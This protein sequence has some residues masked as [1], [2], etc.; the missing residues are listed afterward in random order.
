MKKRVFFLTV[1]AAGI[2]VSFQNCSKMNFVPATDATNASTSG[3]TVTPNEVVA[4][5]PI[6][7]S[8]VSASTPTPPMPTPPEVVVLD[9]V[10]DF[11]CQRFIEM[12]YNPSQVLNIPKRDNNGLCY[13]VKIISAENFKPSSKNMLIDNEVTS[14]NHDSAGTHHPYVLGAQ[15]VRMN[16]GGE[17]AI[18]VSGGANDTANITVDNFILVGIA[19]SSI[20]G[21][22]TY[23]K[24][25]GTSD[26]TL[27]NTNSILFKDVEIPVKA[28]AT[29][30]TSTIA[31]LSLAGLIEINKE[32]TLDFRGLDAGGIGVISDIYILFQ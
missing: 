7:T 1:A 22:P 21:D 31:P 29:G 24:A 23:Y 26:S 16:L 4:E 10:K 17:R 25:Y 12:T 5:E 11:K 8:P 2:M 15:E 19:P 32:Y 20:I 9:V 27:P 30:G 18:K 13:I 14:R 6:N 3:S 28:F